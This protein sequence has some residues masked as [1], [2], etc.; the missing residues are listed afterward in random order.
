[1]SAEA[2]VHANEGHGSHASPAFYWTI[3]GILTVITAVEVAAFYIPFLA[4]VLVPLL[5]LL[6]ATKFLLV[7]MFFMHLKFDSRIF[8]GLFLAGMVLAS[9]MTVALI[10]L[11]HVLPK[12]GV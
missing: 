4:G 1:M 7:V 3:G 9:F 2:A 10:V 12:Y 6:S 11:F 5:L 8:S